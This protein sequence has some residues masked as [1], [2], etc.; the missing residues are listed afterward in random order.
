MREIKK[1]YQGI[2]WG[3]TSYMPKSSTFLF[4]VMFLFLLLSF[5]SYILIFK[6]IKDNHQKN[7]EITFYKIQKSTNTLLTKLLYKF[8][9]QKDI[10]LEKHKE[11]LKY[12]ENNSYDENLNTIYEKINQGLPNKPYNIYITD[13]NLVIKNTTYLP[14]LDFDLSFAKE[15]FEKH[16]LEKTI[17]VSIPIFELYSSNFN[18]YTNSSLEKNDKRILQISF[19]YDDIKVDLKNLQDIIESFKDIKNSD[20][21]LISKDYVGDFMFKS[22]KSYK[23]SNDIIKERISKGKY[24]ANYLK[25]REFVSHYDEDN[26]FSISYLSEKSPIFDDAKII[27]SITFDETQ[28]KEDIFKLNL[29]MFFITILGILAIYFIYKMRYKEFLLSYKDKFIEHSIHEIKTP[30]SI[31]NLNLQLKN[32]V[33]GEDGYSKKMEGALRTLRNSYEDMTFLHTKS[34]INYKVET[35]NLENILKDRIKYFDLVAKTQSRNLELE[36]LNSVFVNISKIELE[37]LIDNNISNAIKYSKINSNIKIIL[38]DNN[39]RFISVGDKIKDTKSIFQ[40]YMRENTSLGGHGIGL[41]IVK[42]ICDKY[43]I[44]IVVISQENQNIFS[45]S[46]NYH[47]NITSKL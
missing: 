6:N 32:E 20:A 15:L 19:T 21:F 13:E 38:K 18:S 16:R 35:L 34:K 7:Q 1:N 31:I 33:S 5:T 25:D 11:V 30:L 10:L 4:F 43:N 22:L 44:K 29:L 42:D 28:F 46:F 39:L 47:T 14:D 37:R 24:L 9:I 27:Y 17:G 2:L 12:L 40:R 26:N 41:S 3:L 45:Y 8:S 36:I 23:I